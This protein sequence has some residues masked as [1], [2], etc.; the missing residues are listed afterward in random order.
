MYRADFCVSSGFGWKV[1]KTIGV[2][3]AK[4]SAIKV[5]PLPV[6]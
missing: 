3:G 1:G 6:V 5:S 2:G 4:S